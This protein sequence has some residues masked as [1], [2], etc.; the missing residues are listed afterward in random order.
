VGCLVILGR[1]AQNKLAHCFREGDMIS[2]TRK[3]ALHPFPIDAQMFGE[4]AASFVNEIFIWYSWMIL[5][6]SWIF[7]V[8]DV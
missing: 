1:L 3:N 5:N 4:R 7:I 2:Q 6:I 8:K